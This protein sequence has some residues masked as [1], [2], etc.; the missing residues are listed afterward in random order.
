MLIEQSAHDHL[1]DQE[2]LF[3]NA[4]TNIGSV[5]ITDDKLHAGVPAAQA[6]EQVQ[7]TGRQ[8][9]S[10]AGE[11]R[12]VVHAGCSVSGR[13]ET[14]VVSQVSSVRGKRRVE[15]A[16]SEHVHTALL[17]LRPDSPTG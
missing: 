4:Y 17:A 14:R 13:H 16:Q 8:R 2:I 11:R 7:R 3:A 9:A 12:V 5:N 6:L 1:V 10:H 15:S